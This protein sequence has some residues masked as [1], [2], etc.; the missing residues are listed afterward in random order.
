M[1][2]NLTKA[3]IIDHSPRLFPDQSRIVGGGPADKGSWPFIVRLKFGRNYLCAGSLIDGET[4]I[5][6]AHCCDGFKYSDYEIF[7]NDHYYRL[8]LKHMTAEFFFIKAVVV[9]NK[10]FLNRRSKIN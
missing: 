10:T 7:L 2:F 5:T 1:F 4:V 6:A 3:N 9:A 8:G